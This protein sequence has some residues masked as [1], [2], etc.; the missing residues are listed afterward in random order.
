MNGVSIGEVS[1]RNL[2]ESCSFEKR[3]LFGIF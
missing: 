1:M 3:A 2:W